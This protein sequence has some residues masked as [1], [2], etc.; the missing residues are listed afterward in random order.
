MCPTTKTAKQQQKDG[1]CK[2]QQITV[3]WK[4]SE[5]TVETTVAD[6]VDSSSG[7]TTG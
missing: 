4:Q 3:G 1:K 2:K 5:A 7:Q 6:V